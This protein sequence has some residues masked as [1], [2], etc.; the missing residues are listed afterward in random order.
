MKRAIVAVTLGALFLSGNVQAQ[1]T[2]FG[3]GVQFT[4]DA[5]VEVSQR[6]YR[7][8][9]LA[10]ESGTKDGVPY[11]IYHSDG[12][13]SFAGEPG[14]ELKL[15]ETGNWSVNCKIDP[16]TDRRH[17]YMKKGDL[18]VWAYDDGR[19]QVMVGGERDSYPHT[20]ATVR[21]DRAAPLSSPASAEGV[22]GPQN[23]RALISQMR[24]GE[25]VVTRYTDWPYRSFV[26]N[27]YTLH[28]FGA[29]YDYIVWAVAN[30]R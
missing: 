26:T 6:P 16:I 5:T 7:P 15:M 25:Q 9:P 21:V 30:M 29:A 2:V 18:W 27:T 12:S 17:C 11:R 8:Q 1:T 19:R 14:N 13:G 22:F 24:A 3:Q 20:Q 23:S 10:I 4:P 28:G